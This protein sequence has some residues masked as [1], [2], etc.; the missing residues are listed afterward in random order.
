M[1]TC[2]AL[3]WKP[4]WLNWY[5]LLLFLVCKDEHQH[6]CILLTSYTVD[7]S[8]HLAITIFQLFLF[9]VGIKSVCEKWFRWQN[10]EDRASHVSQPSW[11]E[12]IAM[13]FFFFFLRYSAWFAVPWCSKSSLLP[14]SLLEE[15]V[16]L[17]AREKCM[18]N[19]IYNNLYQFWA[20][21][22]VFAHFS[23]R[24]FVM[25]Y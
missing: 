2:A 22:S 3:S 6:L 14:F 9:F 23:R 4:I 10:C 19:V 24:S 1:P 7:D 17:K 15:L 13:P 5:F 21:S 11:T 20:E 16:I 8:T 25:W 12:H 18:K